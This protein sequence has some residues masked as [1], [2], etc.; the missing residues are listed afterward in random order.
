[1]NL[2]TSN[3]KPSVTFEFDTEDMNENNKNNHNTDN[4]NFI[5]KENRDN[6]ESTNGLEV[7]Q[8]VF[9]RNLNGDGD[10]STNLSSVTVFENY[11]KKYLMKSGISEQ[12][13]NDL[14]KADA[15]MNDCHSNRHWYKSEYKKTNKENALL[16]RKIRKVKTQLTRLKL[17]NVMEQKS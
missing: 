14:V 15:D 7:T 8:S 6:T 10:E 11:Y 12:L 16:E 9:S 5:M 17:A 4:S 2:S 1:M 13:V 3:S